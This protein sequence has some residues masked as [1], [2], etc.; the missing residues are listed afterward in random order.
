MMGFV[1]EQWQSTGVCAAGFIFLMTTHKQAVLKYVTIT[2]LIGGE[3]GLLLFRSNEILLH[4]VK[5]TLL[6][7]Q[8]PQQT[9]KQKAFSF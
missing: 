5:R 8:N 6:N 3:N 4:T 7:V 1:V 9:E 2:M